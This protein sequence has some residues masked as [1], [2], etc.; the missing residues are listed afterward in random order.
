[1]THRMAVED[2]LYRKNYHVPKSQG[3]SL[4]QAELDDQKAVFFA[5]G[6]V[7]AQIPRGKSG[8][9]I[10]PEPERPRDH[11]EPK[12]VRRTIGLAKIAGMLGVTL[13]KARDIVEAESVPY[14]TYRNRKRFDPA[15]VKEWLA[16]RGGV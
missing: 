9:E 10:P 8:V 5:A 16:K 1:M 11:R 15:V 14:E 6:G 7:I 13:G 12:V 2:Y 4:S 3:P